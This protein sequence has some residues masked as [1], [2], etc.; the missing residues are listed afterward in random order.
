MAVAS[1][2]VADISRSVPDF[3]D[4]I[5]KVLE[6]CDDADVRL[7]QA[8]D[9]RPLAWALVMA[10]LS[11]DAVDHRGWRAP[12]VLCAQARRLMAGWGV[13][14]E[15]VDDA[16]RVGPALEWAMQDP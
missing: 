13:A 14:T 4:E 10:A 3:L 9:D 15:L 7:R 2:V 5:T 11:W 16:D 12:V 8:R 1:R 6:G